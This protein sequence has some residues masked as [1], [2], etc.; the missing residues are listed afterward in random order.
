MNREEIL[1][2][3][4]MQNIKHVEQK[5]PIYVQLKNAI[6]SYIS[7]FQ[8]LFSFK[9]KMALV[10]IV[11]ICISLSNILSQYNNSDDESLFTAAY[12]ISA[13]Y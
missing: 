12:Q 1:Y 2:N 10:A 8:E 4:I 3:K 13:N 9:D 5:K 7:V 6:A 11:F